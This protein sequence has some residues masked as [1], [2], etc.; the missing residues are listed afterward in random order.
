MFKKVAITSAKNIR[1]I[2]GIRIRCNNPNAPYYHCYGGRGIKIC[3]EWKINNDSFYNWAINN[4]FRPG[5]Q[6]DRIDNN[7]GYVKG[8]I[9][10]LC[11]WINNAK[12]T[13]GDELLDEFVLA[14]AEVLATE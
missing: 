7:K 11:H 9:R 5:L 13:Y 14:R 12:S 3:D 6:I 4:G 8:N 1:L 10:L 2:K